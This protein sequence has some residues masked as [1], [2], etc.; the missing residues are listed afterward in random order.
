MF[1]I[2]TDK[3]GPTGA[4]VWTTLKRCEKTAGELVAQDVHHSEFKIYFDSSIT[5]N[6]S[7]P[8]VLATALPSLIHASIR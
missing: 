4:T 5:G 3:S 6:S 8:G 1:L 2:Y 7:P